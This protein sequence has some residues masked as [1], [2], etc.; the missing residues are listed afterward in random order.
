MKTKIFRMICGLLL[1]FS[2]RSASG[3]FKVK[4]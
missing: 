1:I 2:M 4:Y 3:K